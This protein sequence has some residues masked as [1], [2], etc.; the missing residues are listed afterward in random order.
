MCNIEYKAATVYPEIFAA[1][2]FHGFHGWQSYREILSHEN[3]C[4]GTRE[5]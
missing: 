2:N 5:G 1:R 4:S 3:L